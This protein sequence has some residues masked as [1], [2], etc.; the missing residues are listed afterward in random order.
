[1]LSRLVHHHVS[2]LVSR[3]PDDRAE[4]SFLR[5]L[6]VRA[7]P[8]VHPQLRR[9]AGHHEDGEIDRAVVRLLPDCLVPHDAVRTII[10]LGMW[11]VVALHALLF[12][13]LDGLRLW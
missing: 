11:L 10:C 2:R 5:T 9:V 4:A 7:H 12:H 1:M 6:I 13:L 3:L 8:L